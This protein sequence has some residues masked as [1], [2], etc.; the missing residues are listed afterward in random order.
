MTN[1]SLEGKTALITGASRGIGAAVAKLLAKQ[2][3]HVILIARTIGGLEAV[4]DEI[5]SAGGRAT[6]MPL[7]LFKL[8]ELDALGP[9]LYQHFPKLDIFVGN[10]AMLGTLA[11]LGHLKPDE[12]QQVMNLNVM[13][14]YRLI[15]TLDPLIKAAPNGRAVFVTSGVTQDLRAYWG[16]Y[17]VSKA[18]LEALAKVYAAECANTNVK[19]NILDPGRVR[20]AM[21]AQAYPGENPE[22]RPMPDEIAPHFLKLV[23]DDCTMNGE[24]LAVPS[25]R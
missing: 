6:L 19:V 12:F 9:T 14:N 23:G 13:A 17:A 25:T 20:T 24:T 2:G 22:L 11:P 1:H 16:E 7:D 4:D 10:A 15:R 21:R 8:D 5:K 18:A 3:A